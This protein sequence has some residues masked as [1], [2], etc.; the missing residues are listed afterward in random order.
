MAEP[1]QEQESTKPESRIFFDPST[2]AV[3]SIVRIVVVVLI[4]MQLWDVLQY[5][6]YG[7]QRLILLVILSIFP[8]ISL[9]L[10][11]ML[12]GTAKIQ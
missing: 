2:P 6:F 8:Q 7:L 3:R 5:L 9:W 11:D 10:P 12:Y 1:Q 4:M